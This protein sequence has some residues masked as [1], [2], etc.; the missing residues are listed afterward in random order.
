MLKLQMIRGIE[1]MKFKRLK[2][3]LVSMKVL[4]SSL[5]AV[6]VFAQ[7]PSSTFVGNGGSAGD[8][9]LKV[10]KEVLTKTIEIIRDDETAGAEL[11]ACPDR[12][13][14][15]P[16]CANVDSLKK[17]Q[18]EFCGDFI[19]TQAVQLLE[20]L[21]QANFVWTDSSLTV[22]E[23]GSVMSVD[24]VADFRAKKIV[25]N[26]DRFLK[27]ES[28]ER[29][30][31][32]A[33]ELF[34]LTE[35]VETSGGS[36]KKRSPLVDETAIGPFKNA[37]GGRELLNAAA[38]V[39]VLKSNEW[40]IAPSYLVHL[41]RSRQD[42][43]IW[44][45][46]D[47]SGFRAEEDLN[48][49]YAPEKYSGLMLN[50]R[51]FLPEEMNAFGVSFKFGN[52]SGATTT[53]GSINS[54]DSQNIMALGALYR[55][56]PF[57]N[58]LS[59]L[60]QSFIQIGIHY[61]QMKASFVLEENQ[62]GAPLR[63]EDNATARYATADLAYFLPLQQGFWMNVGLQ[64]SQP[65]YIMSQEVDLKYSNSRFATNIGVSYGF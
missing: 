3:V 30:F 64:L 51:Y 19:K 8:L 44:F 49:A 57:Q 45:G 47:Y 4:L 53:F 27:M 29:N 46:V 52:Y 43:Q 24:A 32:I 34:H 1:K 7:T 28:A 23:Q 65:N 15:H 59:F 20:S 5:F 13:K 6:A 14:E 58:K 2:L 42:R 10:T 11:C 61:E 55:W 56:D 26:R 38:T 63:I 50:A 9:E 12:Y 33:H 18:K 21:Q 36:A 16:Y 60:G 54:E 39:L 35:Y 25:L 37:T 40:L 22:K 48:T 17:T 62:V 41:G 31:L